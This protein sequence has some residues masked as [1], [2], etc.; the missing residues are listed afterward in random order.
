MRYSLFPFASIGDAGGPDLR[1]QLR[2]RDQVRHQ[3]V[4]LANL[5]LLD[6]LT[7]LLRGAP[8]NIQIDYCDEDNGDLRLAVV[9]RGLGREVDKGDLIHAGFFL[10][11]SEAST[12]PTQ[13]SSRI[14]RVVC[15]NGALVECE[16][17][18]AGTLAVHENWRGDLAQVVEHSFEAQGLDLETARFRAAMS[19]M[20]MTPY[21][22]LCNLV[23][24][25]ILTEEEQ[26]AVQQ[27]FDAVGDY[28]L[29]GLINAVTRIAAHCR[30]FDDWKRSVE[31]ERLGGEILHGGHQPPVSELA[32]R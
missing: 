17:G 32:Y 9:A 5:E 4:G 22:L 23:A 15:E 20:L 18:Q 1:E 12:F 27:E 2:I 16:Q 28:T 19:Q 8:C 30:D 7:E 11:N 21:E 13:A 29:Y 26:S 10:Q 25:H 24:Q 6:E 3:R 14:Y 31:L